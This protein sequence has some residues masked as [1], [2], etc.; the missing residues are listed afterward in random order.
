MTINSIPGVRQDSYPPVTSLSKMHYQNSIRLANVLQLEHLIGIPTAVAHIVASCLANALDP[1]FGAAEW[2]KYYRVIVEPSDLP[3]EYYTW[4]FSKDV[5][6]KDKLNH[7]THS[8]PVLLP[9]GITEIDKEGN[10][11]QSR[12][13]TIRTM[14]ELVQHPKLGPQLK[15][16]KGGP[17][18][19]LNLKAKDSCWLVMTRE[20]FARNQ[21][22]ETQM[23]AMKI[24][25]ADQIAYMKTRNVTMDGYDVMPKVLDLIT[26][27][28]AMYVSKGECLLSMGSPGKSST[29]SRCVEQVKIVKESYP[30]GGSLYPWERYQ[31]TAQRT[32]GSF[33]S[34]L[35]LFIADD[36]GV[37]QSI[38][39]GVAGVQRFKRLPQPLELLK[40]F[41]NLNNGLQASSNKLS[42]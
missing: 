29:A 13:Y 19:C 40:M 17:S 15:I 33:G 23:N 35:G 31:Y 22:S 8:P 14:N 32:V 20:V 27:V 34:Q 3:D 10:E 16:F 9:R 4:A 28:F 36:D 7:E 37:T 5:T 25:K 26:V 21:S 11:I 6:K 42:S 39:Y 12:H 2:L 38:K 18:G 24:F 41:D 1:P 30:P